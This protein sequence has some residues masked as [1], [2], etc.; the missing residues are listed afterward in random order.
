MEQ[1]ISIMIRDRLS[2][3]TIISDEPFWAFRGPKIFYGISCF[4]SDGGAT[5]G[6]LDWPQN[7]YGISWILRIFE[8]I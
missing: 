2:G 3:S 6:A 7:F 8:K 1:D 5:Y 4:L